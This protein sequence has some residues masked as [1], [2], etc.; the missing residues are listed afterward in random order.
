MVDIIVKNGLVVTPTGV[1]KGGVAVKG[2]KIVKVGCDE[3]LPEAT[4]VI[5]AKGGY[6]IPGLIDPHVHLANDETP[7]PQTRWHDDFITETRGAAYGG[8]T[9]LLTYLCQ[10]GDY[11]EKF[12][13]VKKE[14]NENSYINFGFHFA[15]QNDD[16]IRD[17]K[18]YCDMGVSSFKHFYNCYKGETGIQLGHRHC[19]PDM[20][21]R[22]CEQIAEYGYPAIANTHC[23]EQDII[24]YLEKKVKAEGGDDLAAYTRS[25]PAAL[26]TMQMLHAMEIAKATGAPLYVVHV[27]VKEGVDAVQ[28]ARAQGF[29]IYAETCPSYL[30]LTDQMEDTLGNWGKVNPPLRSQADCDRLWRGIVDGSVTNMGT[31]H[32]PYSRETKQLHSDKRFHN[33]WNALPGFGNGMEHWLPIMM[34]E[35]VNKGRITIEDMVRV[36]STNNAKVFGMY[37]KKGILAEGSDADIVIVDPNKE[38]LID[39]NFYH[40]RGDWS[41]YYGWKVKGMATHTIVN[42]QVVLDDSKFVGKNG[43]G[44]FIDRS[45]NAQRR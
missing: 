31:D 21:W 25:R 38:A 20:L 45:R 30:T 5:D 13:E 26:E 12:E 27:T 1:I 32:C 7:V 24:Y 40:T 23:E 34:T 4:K 28:A 35:G 43:T 2:D 29:N 15:I 8:V 22:S 36:C 18:K 41:I 17:I 44:H 9:T 39:E 37:P 14:G 19:S 33:I 10:L 11:D 3:N 16:H 42:G 6:V